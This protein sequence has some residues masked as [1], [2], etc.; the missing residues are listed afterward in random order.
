MKVLV[1]Y[2]SLV[3]LVNYIWGKWEI[4]PVPLMKGIH[5]VMKGKHDG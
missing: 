4:V 5:G 1:W 2:G 3:D